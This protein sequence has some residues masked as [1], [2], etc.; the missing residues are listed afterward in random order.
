MSDL[1]NTSLRVRGVLVNSKGMGPSTSTP[2]GGVL[3]FNPRE[4]IT[5]EDDLTP[6]KRRQGIRIIDRRATEKILE[7]LG[8]KKRVEEIEVNPGLLVAQA[9]GANVFGERLSPTGLEFLERGHRL[10]K[11]SQ[12]QPLLLVKDRLQLD[13]TE[14]RS[15]IGQSPVKPDNDEIADM[16]RALLFNQDL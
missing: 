9:S 14:A 12:E 13:I 4:G 16:T 5:N 3:R 6:E 10:S 1:A 7:V 15:L 8:I 2:R 11:M